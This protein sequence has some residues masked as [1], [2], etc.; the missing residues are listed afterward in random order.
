MMV[1]L[2]SQMQL[3][4]L[5]VLSHRADTESTPGTHLSPPG[6]ER[7]NRTGRGPGAGQGM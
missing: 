2:Q 7:R 5:E 4:A 1:S 3:Q 6:E